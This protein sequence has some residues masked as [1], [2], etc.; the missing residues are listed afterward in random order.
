MGR[1]WRDWTP[2]RA[3]LTEVAPHRYLWNGDRS[4]PALA[5]DYRTWKA[6][7]PYKPGEAV[8]VERGTRAIKALI[9][10]LF[11][12]RDPMGFRRE[13]YRIVTRTARGLWSRSWE[14]TYPGFIQRGYHRAGLAPDLDGR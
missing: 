1:I 7:V 2:A 3:D 13:K 4:D 5:P 11:P 6:L 14:Y 12:D 9:I 10:D 8:Y